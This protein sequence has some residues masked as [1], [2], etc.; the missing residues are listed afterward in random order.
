MKVEIR[1]IGDAVAFVLP[2]ELSVR[3]GLAPGAE[4]SITELPDGQLVLTPA[5]FN[6][7]RVVAIG[8]EVFRE[9]KDTFEALA[10]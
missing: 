8:R 2:E 4:V 6:R 1:K 3:L 5:E 7:S 9:Y 10:K